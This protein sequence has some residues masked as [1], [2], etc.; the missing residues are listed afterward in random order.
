MGKNTVRVT[1]LTVWSLRA[2]FFFLSL[3]G[4]F[5]KVG[6]LVKFTKEVTKATGSD[7]TGIVMAIND[8]MINVM[9]SN[10]LFGIEH[11]YNIE[12]VA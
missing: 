4:A 5:M 11:T 2:R 10:N 8:E 9:W 3:S 12:V 1:Q 6:D 7:P